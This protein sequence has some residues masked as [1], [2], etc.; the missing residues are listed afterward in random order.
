[1]RVN[2]AQ[3]GRVLAR[4]DQRSRAAVDSSGIAA[5]AKDGAIWTETDAH[6]PVRPRRRPLSGD[7]VG[8]RSSSMCWCGGV[9][10]LLVLGRDTADHRASS[11]V[12]E[13]RWRHVMAVL[14]RS[15]V[16]TSSASRCQRAVR[17][18]D[19]THSRIMSNM[20][21]ITS[22]TSQASTTVSLCIGEA[23]FAAGLQPVRGDKTLGLGQAAVHR[24]PPLTVPSW[25]IAIEV[26]C[27]RQCCLGRCVCEVLDPPTTANRVDLGEAPSRAV[28][29]HSRAPIAPDAAASAFGF[30]GG[31]CRGAVAAPRDRCKRRGRWWKRLP[32]TC[33]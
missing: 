2:L 25:L 7:V 8:V 6:S 32:T 21:G 31:G 14:A 24:P 18:R 17:R 29:R 10:P 19:N 13:K 4:R 9:E 20:D 27:P 23:G 33:T 22:P 26:P 5:P 28:T 30:L 1:M 3:L 12:N 11:S 15:G 16:A